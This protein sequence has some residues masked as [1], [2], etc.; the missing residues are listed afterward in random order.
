MSMVQADNV[1][2]RRLD[3]LCS[4]AHEFLAYAVLI[5]G[6]TLEDPG[7]S[8][9]PSAELEK[10]EMACICP[11]IIFPHWDFASQKI[12]SLLVKLRL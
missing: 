2:I 12:A 3:L 6:K 10:F 1:Q 7:Q 4:E 9:H 11:A 8:P 5:T